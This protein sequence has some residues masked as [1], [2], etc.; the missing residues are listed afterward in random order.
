MFTK[1]IRFEDLSEDELQQWQGLISCQAGFE[2]PFFHPHFTRTV[3]SVRDDIRVIV[4]G[5]G[6]QV[7]FI[8]PIQQSGRSAN[9]VGAPFCDYHGPI[10]A[11]G[12]QG[13]LAAL[14]RS[15]GLST[16]HF[17]SLVDHRAQFTEYVAERDGTFVCYIGN[18]ADAYFEEQRNLYP[19]HAKKLRRLARKV[20]RE[21]GDVTFEF[22]DP[23][24]AALEQVLT[25]KS[26][27][28]RETGRHDVLAPDW[29]RGMLKRL[30]KDGVPGCR[31]VFHTLKHGDR[32][33]AGEFNLLSDKTIHGWIPA[34]DHE[35]WSYSPG[36][37]LQ[38]RII[39]HAAERGYRDYDLGVSA[40]HYKKYYASFQYPVFGG[41][42][43]TS[44]VS[45]A[46]GQAGEHV[47]RGVEN[48]NLP[49]VSALAGK[50]R[51]RY[52]M[53]RTVETTFS[54]RVRGVA[55]AA[56]LM[57]KTRSEETQPQP[58]AED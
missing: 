52:G 57:L 4:Q 44:G 41:T 29:V 5:E 15:V 46:L 19:R 2:S 47:W 3:S 35:F 49:K 55:Q 53:I 56:S 42:V 31:G 22:D 32:L 45:S 58:N 25:W 33:I 37:L 26:H 1:I 36:Y 28:Y 16:Y 9:P 43:R 38:D 54:G 27:Q 39:Q 51:R 14:I 13:D 21:V 34:F 40:A 7:S 20:E 48:A 17:T 12:W 18:G 30:W 6:N 24:E 8:L 23:D 11:P 10:I 50:V